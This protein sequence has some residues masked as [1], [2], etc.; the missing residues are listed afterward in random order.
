MS[1][2]GG[3]RNWSGSGVPGA[4][5]GGPDTDPAKV[6]VSFGPT[7][8]AAATAAL[9]AGVDTAP[10]DT[11][12][13]LAHQT[14]ARGDLHVAHDLQRRV[15]ANANAAGT[16]AADDY[17]FLGLMLYGMKRLDDG[18]AAL[19]DGLSIAPDN[20]ALHENLGVFLLGVGDMAGS[21]DA[22]ERALARGSDSPN[23]HDCLADAYNRIG[24]LDLSVDSGRAA[25]EAKDR[26][27][28][29][30][31]R[32]VGV[33]DGLPPMFNPLN[34][35]ENVIAYCLWG[36]EPRYQVPLLENARIQPHLF[37][38]WSIRVYH[39]ETVNRSYL[40]TLAS[41]GVQLRE[42][43]LPDGQPV[44]RKLLWR[45]D[46]VS[47]PSV[48]RFLCRDADSLLTVKER[49]AVYAWLQSRY[50]FHAMRDWYSHTDLLLAGMWGGVGNILPNL[51]TLLQA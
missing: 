2:S 42:M 27:F 41:R 49:V 47:D 46:V 31:A 14:Y 36:N 11:L 33:P 35:A 50:Y 12:R 1:W 40:A 8:A 29:T 32:L 17:L 24:R 34:P 51:P 39:D 44:H 19:R 6:V 25:L 23:V 30:R 20:A 22:C 26:R 38:A 43:R 21:I 13:N 18:I 37:P 5:Q 45:F 4:V 16:Q 48:K 28:G 3:H 9:P 15:I 10:L 7:A